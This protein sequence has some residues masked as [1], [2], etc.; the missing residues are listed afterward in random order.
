MGDAMSNPFPSFFEC[1]Y[2]HTKHTFPGF[3]PR[4]RYCR[5]LIPEG[6]SRRSF[7]QYWVE[8]GLFLGVKQ[9]QPHQCWVEAGL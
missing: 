7:H 3:T 1:S 8:A 2:L 4:V 5:L 6:R 9:A